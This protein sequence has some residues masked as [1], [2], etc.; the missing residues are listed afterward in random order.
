[1]YKILC[2]LFPCARYICSEIYVPGEDIW[3]K[4]AGKIIYSVN[5]AGKMI[6]G[7]KKAT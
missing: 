5:K 7:M 4:K 2:L 6:S 3:C 1:M